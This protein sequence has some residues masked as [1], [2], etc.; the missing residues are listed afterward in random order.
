MLVGVTLAG[1]KDRL[2]IGLGI[3][4]C[5]SGILFFLLTQ[6]GLREVVTRSVPQS[7]K[8]GLTA[9]IGLFVAYWFSQ[10]RP[11]AGECQ[12]QCPDAG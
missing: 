5:W 3:I 11:G 7:I 10:C 9:S 12:N 8:L 4:A 1:M 2:A 6:F